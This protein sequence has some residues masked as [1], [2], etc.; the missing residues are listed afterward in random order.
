MAATT[1]RYEPR[2]LAG[3]LL[4]NEGDFFE[5]HEVW[6]DLWHATVGPDRSFYQGLI[7]VA[8]GLCHYH[9]G[10]WRGAL[11]LHESS[12]GY[13]ARFHPEHL[14]L[15][16][17]RFV[18]QLR[19]CHE[20]LRRLGEGGSAPLDLDAVPRIELQPAPLDWPDPEGFIPLDEDE[21]G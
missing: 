3:I 21:P 10:N 9:N 5:A 12:L 7:Q 1:E 8:V 11:K 16:L 14:G 20:P 4:F 2:Y 19:L 17:D 13:L 6:E 15:P 18:A